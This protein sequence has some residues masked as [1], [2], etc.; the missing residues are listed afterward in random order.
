MRK[1]ILPLL[2]ILALCLLLPLTGCEQPA[3][4]TD[5][6]QAGFSQTPQ[7]SVSNP[8]V[9]QKPGKKALLFDVSTADPQ[10]MSPVFGQG[11][12]KVLAV[13]ERKS[14]GYT[15]EVEI[16]R[17]FP[18]S[19]DEASQKQQSDGYMMISYK[20][21]FSGKSSEAAVPAEAKAALDQ[22]AADSKGQRFYG[23]LPTVIRLEQYTVTSTFD[24]NIPY[25]FIKKHGGIQA[26]PYLLSVDGDK[27]KLYLYFHKLAVTAFEGELRDLS[28]AVV[29]PV[30]AHTDAA[31][32]YINDKG[33][34]NEE[35]EMQDRWQMLFLGK[36]DGDSFSGELYLSQIEEKAGAYPGVVSLTGNCS[37]YEAPIE[38][39]FLPF[40]EATYR[41]AGGQMGSIQTA[42]LSHMATADC[43]GKSVLLT[44]AGDTVYV[45]LPGSSFQGVFEGKL[46]GNGGQINRIY[47]ESLAL[48]RA[49]YS[50]ST[51][52]KLEAG[53]GWEAGLRKNIETAGIKLTEEQLALIQ[54]ASSFM[55][56]LEGQCLWLPPDFIP[57][58]APID[59]YEQNVLINPTFDYTE[60]SLWLESIGPV[61]LQRFSKMCDFSVQEGDSGGHYSME[62][63]FRYGGRTIYIELSDG[64]VGT[65]VQISMF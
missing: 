12:C 56:E 43:Q 58:T 14:D 44:A 53:D 41:M 21:V 65:D 37:V 10:D 11:D 19:H 30:P 42:L 29:P 50:Y 52:S 5:T 28:S 2:S 54:G 46:T 23:V 18:Q 4:D 1:R 57:F 32:L 63:V 39:R 45:E 8:P 48:C 3:G 17:K 9:S 60:D 49:E 25:D 24:F 31:R 36:N 7:S 51:A 27:A 6:A 13:F 33:L 22:L 61:Y 26:L 38:L 20:S 35:R 16:T 55:N 34:S 62:I 59:C 64:N 47:E 15:G 40:D